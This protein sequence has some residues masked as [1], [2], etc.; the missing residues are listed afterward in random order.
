[1]NSINLIGN[2]TKDVELKYLPGSGTAVA[3]FT[4][5]VKRSF[6]KSEEEQQADFIYIQTFGKSAENCA[7]YLEKGSK[8]AIQGELRIDT[9]Q[10]D[11]QHHSF[12]KVNASRVEFLS[13]KGKEQK[14]ETEVAPVTDAGFQTIND[15]DIPF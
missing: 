8:V 7:N 10:K 11:G 15:D 3:N 4:I 14:S 1:M 12:T 5:A 9:Y 6:V 13:S 2:L